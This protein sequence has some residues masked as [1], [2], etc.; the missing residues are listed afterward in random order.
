[1]KFIFCFSDVSRRKKPPRY[2]NL[3]NKKKREGREKNATKITQLFPVP[4]PSTSSTFCTSNKSTV[5]EN[6]ENEPV[7]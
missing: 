5:I 3:V 6:Y 7:S 2:Q 4:S 1:M